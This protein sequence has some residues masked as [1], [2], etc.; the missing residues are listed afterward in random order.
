VVPSSLGHLW[1]I[2]NSQAQGRITAVPGFLIGSMG[3][4]QFP[5]STPFLML[6]SDMS[7]TVWEGILPVS[8]AF[9]ERHVAAS[10]SRNELLS[11]VSL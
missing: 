3:K 4:K 8:I 10:D 7:E 6:Y 2:A 1:S 11:V 5:G 9:R